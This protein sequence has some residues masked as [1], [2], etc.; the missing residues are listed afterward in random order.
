MKME[1]GGNPEKAEKGDKSDKVPDKK[2]KN[3]K[4]QK[5]DK[6]ADKKEKNER[7]EKGA[8]KKEKSEKTEKG[9]KVENGIANG[10]NGDVDLEDGEGS[11]GE[12]ELKD[13][14]RQKLSKVLVGDLDDL[15]PLGS[16]IVRI[17]TSST[18]TGRSPRYL[19]VILGIHVIYMLY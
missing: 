17:F 3:E 12:E 7:G 5:S 16:K 11:E 4:G 14:E 8:D 6:V 10:V 18:F 15:P 9:D 19:H 2:E 1:K 13:E